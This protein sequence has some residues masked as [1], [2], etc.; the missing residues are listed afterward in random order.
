MSEDTIKVWDIAVR[1]FH[2]SLVLLFFIS[3]ASEDFELVHEYSGYAVLFLI[4]FRVVWGVIG[5]KY[6]RFSDFVKRPSVVISYLRT[7]VH[8]KRYIGHNPAGGAMVVVLLLSITFTGI[9]GYKTM[10]PDSNLLMINSVDVSLVKNALADDD[11]DEH[12]GDE[13][14]EEIHEFFANATLFF[15]AI[16]VLGVLYS[17]LIHN[18]NLIRSMIDGKKRKD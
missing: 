15:I 9:T 5:T 3:Y 12:E 16:H 18:E 10:Y 13:F 14:W 11:N 2:W 17:S 6:A 4:A 8:P 7:L 1:V